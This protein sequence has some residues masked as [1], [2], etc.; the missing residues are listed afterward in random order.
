MPVH[1]FLSR[2]IEVLKLF[3]KSNAE[4]IQLREFVADKKSMY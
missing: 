3:F 2:Y 1:N 4:H